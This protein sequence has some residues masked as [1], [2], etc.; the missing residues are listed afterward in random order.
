MPF[1]Q[2][3]RRCCGIWDCEYLAVTMPDGHVQY[4]C[5]GGFITYPGGLSRNAKLVVAD[6]DYHR[7][8]Y[9]GEADA[10]TTT[11]TI[12]IECDRRQE[13]IDEG[14]GPCIEFTLYF[15]DGFGIEFCFGP[16]IMND[17]RC[18]CL[19]DDEP[20]D[21]VV[22]FNWGNAYLNGSE[23]VSD[24]SCSCDVQLDSGGEVIE[25]SCICGT[26]CP[27]VGYKKELY[28]IWDCPSFSAPFE[29]NMDW[30]D[31]ASLPGG[32][33]TGLLPLPNG[34]WYGTGTIDGCT[35]EVQYYCPP[36]SPLSIPVNL[37]L[38]ISGSSTCEDY[39]D[40]LLG[41]CAT[42]NLVPQSFQCHDGDTPFERVD[43]F[44]A[45]TGEVPCS[46]GNIVS[47]ITLTERP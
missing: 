40:P 31:Y 28:F 25:V 2:E 3:P 30:Y 16:V 11:Y 17:R 13:R 24:P 43:A 4:D 7:W 27:C 8:E 33:T 39:G 19:D 6:D 12:V 18:Q 45:V 38:A 21:P 32:A 41:I 15:N 9:N 20:A 1:S 23:I 42:P 44:C 46:P 36:E 5:G 37:Y 14:Y 29:C 35:V 22:G 34:V 47:T 26:Q 10:P